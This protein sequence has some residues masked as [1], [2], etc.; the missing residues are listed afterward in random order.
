MADYM[1]LYLPGNAITGMFSAATTGR[2]TLMVT[3]DGTVGPASADAYVVGVAGTDAAANA[4]GTYYGR[5]T[6]HITTTAGA[7]TA[8]S[9]AYA[10]ANGTIDDTGTKPCG[11]FL[12]SAAPGATAEWMEF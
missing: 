12:T 5:G 9:L 11:I 10:G 3:G 2:Q 4:V 7:V 8:G 6:V 1:P